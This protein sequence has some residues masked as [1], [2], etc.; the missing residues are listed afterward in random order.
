MGWLVGAL[1]TVMLHAIIHSHQNI[2][3]EYSVKENTSCQCASLKLQPI[4]LCCRTMC[5]L[6]FLV[7]QQMISNYSASEGGH[8][9]HNASMLDVPRPR[10]SSP[11]EEDFTWHLEAEHRRD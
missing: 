11:V 1:I 2:S 7:K 6:N 10:K 9:I 3:R 8:A 4:F 5:I